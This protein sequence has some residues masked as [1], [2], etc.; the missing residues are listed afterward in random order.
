MYAEHFLVP[1]P[2]TNFYKNKMSS[3]VY[4]KHNGP[5]NLLKNYLISNHSTNIK[6]EKIENAL[7]FSAEVNL[8]IL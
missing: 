2:A 4:N 5:D 6:L 8:N 3:K 7:T 1:C